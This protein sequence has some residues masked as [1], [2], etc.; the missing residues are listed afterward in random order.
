MFHRLYAFLIEPR[1][2]DE[3]L[4]NR[5]LVLNVL[6]VGTLLLL[7]CGVFALTI[8][9]F[10]L[11]HRYVLGQ[12]LGISIA[13]GFTC[14]T[15]VMSRAGY[16]RLAAWLLV[17]LYFIL[18][19]SVAGQWGITLPSAVALFA[20]IIMITGIVLGARYPL[21]VASTSTLVIIALEVARWHGAI[22][23]DLTWIKE[24]TLSTAIGYCMVFGIIALVSWL[25]NHQIERSLYRARRAEAAL[26]RQKELLETTVEKRTRELQAAQF[27]K[28]QQLYRFAELGQISTA[29]LHELAGHLTS[30][31]IDIEGLEA[32]EHSQVMRRA[33][34]SIHYIDDMV[35]RVRDQLQGK[36]MIKP[37]A[38]TSEIEEVLGILKHRAARTGVALDLVVEGDRAA[39]RIK[40]DSVRFRQLI[41]NIITN[42]IDAY[43]GIN[44]S[45]KTD[46]KAEIHVAGKGKDVVITVT[47]W[48]A[49]IPT[50]E[51]SK[52]F[53]PFYSTKE[54]GMG[55]GLSIA[56]QIVE[57]QFG[58]KIYLEDTLEPTTFVIKLPRA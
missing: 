45:R 23:P 4:R 35:L 43:G 51:R 36:S 44:R 20:L 39:L 11:D 41:A 21:Y 22:K 27:E 56:Q 8:N 1:Q 53:D 57:G 50:A 25:F 13:F 33:K 3:D 47:D 29:L 52:L 37:L 58:G 14:W 54:V 34:R 12:M 38:V 7:L 18:A 55:M 17:S 24:S 42:A 5:E 10:I 48:G 26:T 28:I 46:A 15:Y 6:L 19:T 16:H 31:S 9:Y 32:K 49:G 2:T 30:L 40:G